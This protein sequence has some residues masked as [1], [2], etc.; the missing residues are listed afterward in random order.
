MVEVLY[1]DNHLIAVCKPAGLLT[2]ETAENHESLENQVKAWIKD[3][4]QKPGNVFLGV[5][6]RLDRPV[7]GIVLFAKTSKAL[8]RLNEA[9]RSR[10]MQK[11]YHAL[12]EGRPAQ[13]SATL[14][15]WLIHDDYRAQVCMRAEPDAK[16]ARLHYKTLKRNPDTTLLEVILETGRYHQIR[17]QCAA[18]GHPIVGD[19]KYGSRRTFAEGAIALHHYQ[20]KLEHPITKAPLM[21]VCEAAS[22]RGL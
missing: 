1:E 15:H 3:K 4:Y 11:T 8:S 6:H 16:K 14:E 18:I 2:Q 12:V 9:I 20:L 22:L 19:A 13:E 21:I 5:I 10:S 7:S 17:A